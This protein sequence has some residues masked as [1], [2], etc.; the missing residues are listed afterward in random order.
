[1][2]LTPLGTLIPLNYTQLGAKKG[3]AP[4]RFLLLREGDI[5][6]AGLQGFEMNAEIAAKIIARFEAHG[7]DIPI[8]YHHATKDVEEH[9]RDKAPAV[10]WIKRLAYVKGEGLYAEDIQWVNDKA[11]AEV[12]AGEYKYISPVIIGPKGTTEIQEIHS[13]ALTNTPRTIN[14]PELLA[15]AR[16]LEENTMPKGTKDKQ[17][18]AAQDEPEAPAL[19]A[20]QKAM[21]DLIAALT[22]AGVQLDP[23]ASQAAV[24]IA[25]TEF[26]NAHSEGAPEEEEEE[27]PAEGADKAEKDKTMTTEAATMAAKAAGYDALKD[28]LAEAHKRLEVIDGERKAQRIDN[29]IEKAIADNRINPNDEQLIAASRKLAERDET[30]F[31]EFVGSMPV[32]APGESVTRGDQPVKN[33]REQI[34]A[35]ALKDYEKEP[36]EMRAGGSTRSYVNVVLA[37]E[38]EPRLTDAEAETLKG[39]K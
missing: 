16:L 26:V 25:A 39:A 15:A 23:G 21:A 32:Y 30:A 9:K 33:K 2:M 12:E 20:T 4:T 27:M 22:G 6:W 24:L 19:D 35:G 1:M 8:D 36:A 3:T 11:K 37:E 31:A 13:V 28:Q 34:I 7:A 5:G 14:A 17:L 38:N 18:I 10:A 29:L